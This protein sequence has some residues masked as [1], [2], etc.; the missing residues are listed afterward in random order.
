MKPEDGVWDVLEDQLA[1]AF[2]KRSCPLCFRG[3]GFSGS[4]FRGRGCGGVGV[5]VQGLEI[6]L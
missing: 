6:L 4:G 3:W 1:T 5:G 2:T